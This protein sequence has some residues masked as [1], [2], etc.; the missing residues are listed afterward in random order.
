MKINNITNHSKRSGIS[1]LIGL[2]LLS[3]NEYLDIV[4]DDGMPTLETAFSM[5]TTAR[6]YLTTCYS[7]MP[8]NGDHSAD[9]TIFGGDELW[10]L[11]D[12]TSYDIPNFRI[13]RGLQNATS[14]FSDIWDNMYKAIRVCNIF[15]ENIPTVPDIPEWER[16][17]WISEAKVLKAYYHF[18]L[19][20]QYGPIPVVKENLSIDAS[21]EAVRVSRDPADE[22]FNYIIQLLNEA[23]PDLPILVSDQAELGRITRPIA[24][25]LKAKVA[26]FYAS[27][28]FTEGNDNKTLKNR[29]GKRLFPD[30]TEDQKIARWNVAAEA[31][32]E[33]I[34]I[35]R[36]ANIELFQYSTR[37]TIPDT[38]KLQQTLRS[39]VTE[40]WN[41]EII[42][43]NTQTP[44]IWL[45]NYEYAAM[46]NLAR[47]Q[48]PDNSQTRGNMGVN[49]K[50]AD[51][52]YTDNGIPLE[53]DKSWID[54]DPLSLRTG[55]EA[56]KWYIRQ[57]YVTAQMNFNR[58]PRFYAY[59]CFDGG[60]WYGQKAETNDPNPNDLYWIACRVGGDQMRID[61]F[62]GPITGYYNKKMVHYQT[63]FA[64]A[65]TVT[66]NFYPWPLM[67][68]SDLLLL[69][70]EAINEAEGPNG[71]RS[72]GLFESIDAVRIKAGVEG[73]KSAYGKYAINSAKYST[74][75]GMREIIHRERLIELLFEGHRFWD[76]RRWKEAPAE[77][78]KPIETF[79]LT[80]SAP[81]DYYKR[82]QVFEQKFSDKDYFWPIRISI[83]EQNPNLIQNIGW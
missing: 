19:I 54:I 53:E 47:R 9:P 66:H 34:D 36:E 18:C 69:Y 39:T 4:P 83:I 37:I 63:V 49:L 78:A 30:V 65:S 68:Y 43:T 60:I 20:R 55:G 81:E 41:S 1:L 6:R 16:Q 48:Y 67:R 38:I 35:C 23:I 82:L 75:Q 15:L 8:R 52:F 22:G 62:S 64:S 50:I 10:Y 28:L 42:W 26:V 72:A 77:Y 31:C 11:I 73:I 14:P 45:T 46:P 74:R 61:I 3:C 5:R 56:E 12:P 13:A 71:P 70:A 2:C 40:I 33:A 79:N 80:M 27:P 58:E 24:A 29:D 17:Q 76:L 32:R 21:V 57:N 7:F 25:S 59:L 51:M 44:N